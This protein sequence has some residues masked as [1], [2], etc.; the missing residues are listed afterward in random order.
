MCLFGTFV[1]NILYWFVWKLDSKPP[2]E[3]HLGIVLLG[4]VSAGLIPIV[5][6]RGG[7]RERAI[8]ILTV[9]GELVDIAP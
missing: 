2:N 7:P 4:C 3:E 9:V 6:N 8:K 1:P 5:I